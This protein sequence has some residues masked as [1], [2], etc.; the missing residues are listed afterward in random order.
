MGGFNTPPADDIHLGIPL[1][2]RTVFE[3]SSCRLAGV[4]T[5]YDRAPSVK[6][7]F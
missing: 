3:G 6:N 1:I 5:V 4:G 7:L 2:I